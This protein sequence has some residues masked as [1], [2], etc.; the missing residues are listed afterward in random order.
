M[1]YSKVNAQTLYRIVPVLDTV[2]RSS[3]VNSIRLLP[4]GSEQHEVLLLG[5]FRK[6][7]FRLVTTET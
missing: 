7:Y 1:I 4:A 6:G 3:L 5:V 2:T